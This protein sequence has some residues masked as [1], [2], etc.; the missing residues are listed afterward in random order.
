MITIQS[1]SSRTDMPTRHSRRPCAA[2]TLLCT[3]ACLTTVAGHAIDQTATPD[4]ATITSSSARGGVSQMS[5][6]KAEG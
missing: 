4:G 1:R 2:I 3:V 6:M 5:A